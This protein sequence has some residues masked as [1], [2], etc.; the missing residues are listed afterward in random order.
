VQSIRAHTNVPF[1]EKIIIDD[2]GD[3]AYQLWLDDTFPEF[4]RIHHPERQGLGACFQSALLA[5]MSTDADYGFMV[6]DDTPLLGYVD[7]DGMSIVLQS[8]AYLSQLMLARP[9]F[10]D[11]EI[12]AGGVFQQT[13]DDFT[14]CTNGLWTWIEHQKWYGFQPHLAPR[15]IIEDILDLATSFLELGVT[16]ALPSYKFGYWGGLDDPPLCAHTGTQRS[17]NYRW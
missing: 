1:V 9:A 6:E 16:V 8:H 14:E 4:T 17:A 15:H 2:S 11:A 10:N 12:A 13:P 3:L 7:I 5:V